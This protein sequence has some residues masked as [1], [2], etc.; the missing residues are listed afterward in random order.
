MAEFIRELRHQKTTI[1][2]IP[3]AM[4]PM[5]MQGALGA[6]QAIGGL[7]GLRDRPEYEIPDALKQS[8]ALARARVS[9]PY[10]EGYTQATEQLDLQT[11][12][13]IRAAQESGNAQE[14]I[15]GV[16]G[17]Q[18]RGASDLARMNEES[19]RRDIDSLVSV[20][21]SLSQAQD[22]EWQM[23]EFAPFADSSREARD[24]FGA[25]MENLYGALDKYGIASIIQ[26]GN[27]GA[28]SSPMAVPS[29]TSIARGAAQGLNTMQSMGSSAMN[30]AQNAAISP[31]DLINLLSYLRKY[32]IM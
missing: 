10:M 2:P 24:V 1:M 3:A 20:L 13:A 6:G 27:I 18:Q 30:A 21:G 23:N 19:Q 4:I 28:Q 32:R 17:A 31:N 26:Q 7:M 5:I 12:N 15:A 29:A 9:N 11:A 8:V 25:G 22:Q 14:A 16:A